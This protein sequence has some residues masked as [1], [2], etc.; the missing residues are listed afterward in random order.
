MLDKIERLLDWIADA[1][2][3]DKVKL[4]GAISTWFVIVPVVIAA[5][6]M[7]FP[8]LLA[9]LGMSIVIASATYYLA[10]LTDSYQRRSYRSRS[11]SRT[12]SKDARTRN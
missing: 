3:F 10:C 11:E 2:E 9:V 5:S 1:W 8:Y 4:L 7:F 12:T 6:I